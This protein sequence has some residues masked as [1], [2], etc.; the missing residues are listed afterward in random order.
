M[1]L[2]RDGMRRVID[3]LVFE[4]KYGEDQFTQQFAVLRSKRWSS[5]RQ[6]ISDM[7]CRS[8][9]R[10]QV[11]HD[12]TRTQPSWNGQVTRFGNLLRGS[13]VGC[14]KTRSLSGS[15]RVAAAQRYFEN[16]GKALAADRKTGECDSFR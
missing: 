6:V 13:E 15:W 9:T 11:V 16:C 4:G 3:V 10:S 1:E 5:S 8:W 14:W 2:K 12:G 7:P